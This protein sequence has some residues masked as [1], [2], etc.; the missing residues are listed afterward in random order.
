MFVQLLLPQC[1]R[2]TIGAE[3]G[4]W[5]LSVIEPG[6]MAVRVLLEALGGCF[7]WLLRR[8][9]G[10]SALG[11]DSAAVSPASA[12]HRDHLS[13]GCVAV[14]F[15]RHLEQSRCTGKAQHTVIKAALLTVARRVNPVAFGRLPDHCLGVKCANVEDVP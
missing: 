2:P 1:L 13:A 7:W 8:L 4:V 3:P 15:A 12:C 14:G 6:D 5:C 10:R 9:M 11:A